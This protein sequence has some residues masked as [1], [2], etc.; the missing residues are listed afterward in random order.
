MTKVL[1]P[2]SPDFNV[3]NMYADAPVVEEKNEDDAVTKEKVIS[4]HLQCFFASS[5]LW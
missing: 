1:K 4:Q 2:E 3:G 5:F